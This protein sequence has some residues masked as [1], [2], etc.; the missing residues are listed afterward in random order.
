MF[1]TTTVLAQSPNAMSYQTVIRNDEQ[2][3]VTNQQVGIQI[4]I[5][6]GSANGTAVYVETQTPISN[7]NGLLSIEIGGGSI[8]SGIF[9]SIDWSSGLYFI[10]TEIDIDGGTNYTITGT[11]QLLSVPFALHA[12][13]AA[14]L[15]N[16]VDEVD[17]LY[18]SSVAGGITSTD[19]ANW[20]NKIDNYI[21]S[22]NMAQVAIIGNS[23][24][25]QI[26]D[27]IDPSEAQDA[28]TKAYVDILEN[29]LIAMEEMLIDGGYY[30]VTDIEGYT[31][32]T[33]KIGNQLWMA[34]NL[35][36]T[37][38]S[39]GTEIPITSDSATWTNLTTPACCWYNN[40]SLTYS[41]TYGTLYNWFTVNTENICPS[42][43]HVP[44]SEE[45]NE[46][47]DYLGGEFVAGDKLK[48]VG[49]A[50][51]KGT[52]TEATNESGFTALP[53]GA[54]A[55]YGSFMNIEMHGGWWSSD[56]VDGDL[57]LVPW[58]TYHSGDI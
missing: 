15:T 38:F 28:A 48:E 36:T 32:K 19:T 53:G 35:K 21:E 24:N 23:V 18:S 41:A 1:I 47:I 14:S 44:I 51:W 45:W 25:A 42:G 7:A 10:K 27:V 55:Y 46:L 31:Y 17:P 26:K 57:V 54:R 9:S 20:N 43:W 39:D 12:T 5:L 40:D 11:S 50:H 16:P 52:N 33:T 2:N 29:K 58:V 34:E 3:L 13:T 30:T 4:S 22:Q 6:Q 37:T 49:T 56:E 8:V